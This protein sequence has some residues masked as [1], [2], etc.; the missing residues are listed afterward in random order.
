MIDLFSFSFGSLSLHEGNST[1]KL[2]ED[3][4]FPGS[5]L[6]LLSNIEVL[7]EKCGKSGIQITPNIK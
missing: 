3:I 2:Y 5:T 6:I 1:V 4:D 7:H